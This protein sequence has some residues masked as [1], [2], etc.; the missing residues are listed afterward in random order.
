MNAIDS[1]AKGNPVIQQGDATAAGF[2]TAVIGH[3][4][5]HLAGNIPLLGRI[6]IRNYFQ[7]ATERGALFTESY[8]YQGMRM[9][10]PQELL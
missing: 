5:G 10:D 2:F 6:G 3:E 4:G 7:S 9:N 8:T 1:F